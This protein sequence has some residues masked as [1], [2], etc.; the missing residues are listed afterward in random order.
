MGW[1]ILYRDSLLELGW[2]AWAADIEALDACVW[3]RDA[4]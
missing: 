1:L 4:V 2:P 3:S